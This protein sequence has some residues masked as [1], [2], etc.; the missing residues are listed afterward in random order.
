MTSEMTT[1]R[2]FGV[3]LDPIQFAAELA[4]LKQRP[5]YEGRALY[6]KLPDEV[7]RIFESPLVPIRHSLAISGG[8]ALPVAVATFQAAGSQVV[9][10]VPLATE[11]ARAWLVES[12]EKQGRIFVAVSIDECK[13]MVVIQAEPPVRDFTGRDWLAV[14]ERLSNWCSVDRAS[15]V[16][17]M[18][19]VLRFVEHVP[20]SEVA[21]I[22]VKERWIFVCVPHHQDGVGAVGAEEAGEAVGPRA[23]AL[24]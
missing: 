13:Q 3:V 2:G 10:L 9:C 16:M 17:D 23:T 19:E 1:H 5:K 8:M 12:V 4:S 24:H 7:A 6:V 11:E 20:E 21:G 14:K 18:L 15:E 22:A